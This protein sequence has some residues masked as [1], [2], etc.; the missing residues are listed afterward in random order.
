M[1][2]S[3]PCIREGKVIL[4]YCKGNNGENRLIIGSYLSVYNALQKYE[5]VM[6]IQQEK[7]YI[8]ESKSARNKES[9]G[10]TE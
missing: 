6:K 8:Y 5:K 10:R 7:V 1:V 4:W 9:S 2:N 3:V